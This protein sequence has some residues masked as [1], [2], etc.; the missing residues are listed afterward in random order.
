MSNKKKFHI[1]KLFKALDI[2]NSNQLKHM[3]KLLGSTCAELEFY[4]NNMI[5]PEGK[6][7]QSIL[8]LKNW[9]ELELKI[10][11]GV[12][13]NKVIDWLS[14]N[15]EY[16]VENFQEPIGNRD[17]NQLVEPQYVG[18]GELYQDDCIKVMRQM[19]DNSIQLIFA[20][21]PFNLDKKYESNIDDYVSEEEYIRW[22]EEWLLECIRILEPGGSIFIYN[23]PYWNT[24][25]AS[26][27]NKYLNFRHWI[28]ISMKGLIPVQRKLHPEHYGLLYYV[29]GDKP[30][31]FN[32]QR[33][34]M[35]TCKHCGRE[36]RD[37]GGKKKDLDP[38]GLSIA[39]IFTDINPVRHKKYKNREANELPLKLLFRIISLASNEGDTVFDPFGG[40][41]TTYVVAEYLGRQWI[42]VE[43]GSVEH[44]IE[45]INNPEKDAQLLREIERKSNV[46]FTEEQVKLRQDN[47]LWGY[48]KLIKKIEQ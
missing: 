21:P 36:I 22:T 3:A 40:S 41:G 38:H 17:I 42:G 19:E 12:L 6:I 46:L 4:N 48:E 15:P 32:K 1:N 26:I 34:P 18:H 39:D 45:R 20:D 28:G 10:R 25:I 33:I 35:E 47:N 23:I 37:Y 14:N 44:I 31:V 5:F 11:L 9:S 7:L 30:K 16:I 29:K 24:H 8:Q 27:L 2:S 43:L 13:D